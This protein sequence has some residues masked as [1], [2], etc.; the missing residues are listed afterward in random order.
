[1]VFPTLKAT[2]QILKIK[3]IIFIGSLNNRSSVEPLINVIP[4]LIARHHIDSLIL[5]IIG[6][7]SERAHFEELVSTLNISKYVEFTG[8]VAT[9]KLR[10]YVT[11]GSLGLLLCPRY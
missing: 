6:D 3:E 11:K 5:R 2:A 8:W 9:E 10:D 4:A 1:M 7:G